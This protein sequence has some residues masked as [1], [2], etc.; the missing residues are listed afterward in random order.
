MTTN[1]RFI[2]K[3]ERF[4]DYMFDENQL[5][6]FCYSHMGPSPAANTMYR[7]LDGYDKAALTHFIILY[8]GF[9]ELDLTDEQR[10]AA[11]ETGIEFCSIAELV[12]SG[13]FAAELLKALE[14]SGELDAC[15]D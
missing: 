2:V 11:M 6:A 12:Q 3:D 1:G 13:N 5:M 15:D 10:D 14:A 8:Y 9:C 7:L 4:F